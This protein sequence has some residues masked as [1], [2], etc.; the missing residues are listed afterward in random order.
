METP[1]PQQPRNIFEV[2]NSNIVA[3]SEDIN[4]M[5]QKIDAIY[6]ALYQ[7]NLSRQEPTATGEL[8]ADDIQI[9]GD[10]VNS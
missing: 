3:L 6:A 8:A 4:L 2:I 5:H 9:S 7:T 1:N 10:H